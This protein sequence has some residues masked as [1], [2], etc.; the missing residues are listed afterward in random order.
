MKH[1]S[2]ICII[3]V[4]LVLLSCADKKDSPSEEMKASML[5]QDIASILNNSLIPGLAV[6]I[7]KNGKI[8]YQESF[9]VA[10]IS[11]AKPYENNTTQPIAS[12]SKTFIAASLMKAVEQGHFKMNANINDLLP[13]QV[14]NPNTPNDE[15]KI[16]H[17]VTHTSGLLDVQDIY[18]G[19]YYMLQEGSTELTPA[20]Q[21]QINLIGMEE[22][23]SVPLGEY[24]EAYYTPGGLIYS[25]Y[26]FSKNAAGDQF[27]YSNIAASLAAYIIEAKTGIPYSEYVQT[28]ILGPLGMTSSSYEHNK[29]DLGRVANLYFT[30]S[31]PYPIYSSFSYPDG[32]LNTSNEDMGKY[33][34]E[35]IRG[36]NGDGTSSNPRK[37]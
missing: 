6:S 30:K 23:D 36:K 9:G 18:N 22:E 10:N 16:S 8:A 37:L 11:S 7:V 33:L 12:I 28:H 15:I 14:T 2:Y 31:D 5:T 17:L 3:A 32:F 24:L 35:M 29:L 27:N 13:F 25:M 1:S 34:L 20:M 19:S 4:F 26:N 21:S